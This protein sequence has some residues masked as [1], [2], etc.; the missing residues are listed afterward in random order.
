MIFRLPLYAAAALVVPEPGWCALSRGLER[1]TSWLKGARLSA[2]RRGLALSGLTSGGDALAVQ[3]VAAEQSIAVLRELLGGWSPQLHL[4][5]REHLDAARRA[6]RGAVLWVAHFG[7]A[8]LAAK[9]ALAR[10]G[11]EVHHVSRPE[12]GFSK[13]RFG[14]RV[15]NPLRVRAERPY[16]AGR[17]V[18]DRDDP[19]ASMA[20]ARR[21]LRAN[22]FVSVTAGAWEGQLVGKARIAQG[23]IELA[24]GAPRLAHLAA[25]PLLP[26]FTVRDAETGIISLVIEA[27]IALSAASGR[28]GMI[29]SAVDDFA[30]RHKPYLAM[31]PL[32]WRDWDKLVQRAAT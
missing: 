5:G 4:T 28:D 17:I 12:H 6:G 13:S 31:A 3:A 7:F 27:P 2:I 29:A 22:A 18:I 21:V 10:A 19:S 32:Q 20:L 24:A 9:M 23:E 11:Y 8:S 26:V 25:A 30:R 1:A 16:L 14:I 15:L